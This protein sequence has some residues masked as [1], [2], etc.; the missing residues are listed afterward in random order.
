M[1]A[2]RVSLVGASLFA[3]FLFFVSGPGTRIGLWEWQ[4]AFVLMRWAMYTGFFIAAVAL[5]MLLIPK[6]RGTKPSLLV[7]ALLMGT[8]AGAPA[9][10]LRMQAQSLPYIHD[11]TTDTRNPPEF[12]ALLAARKA[13]PN[14]AD[15]GG[16]QVPPAQIKGP[17]K[18]PPPVL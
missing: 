17:P 11:V 2:A 16:P 6:T 13:P 1:Q 15:Y 4:T 12:V 18:L 9:M 8:M 14:G 7:A 10:S 3:A 5:V